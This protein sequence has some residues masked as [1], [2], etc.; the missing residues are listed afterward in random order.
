[1]EALCPYQQN[2]IEMQDIEMHRMSLRKSHD[3]YQSYVQQIL[4]SIGEP[5]RD[6]RNRYNI[7]RDYN[8]YGHAFT[9]K[10]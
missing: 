2:L 6:Y 4:D 8:I 1:M 3:C 5:S 7:T 9:K 10:G